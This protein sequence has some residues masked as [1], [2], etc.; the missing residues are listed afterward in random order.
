MKIEYRVGN[1][2][3]S[4]CKHILHG[5]NAQGVMG[6]G[7]AKQIR[8]KYP[9]AFADYRDAYERGEVYLGNVITSRQNDGVTIYNAISQETYGRNGVHVS[10]DALGEIFWRLNGYPELEYE[11]LA[12]PKI[13]AGL[14]GG[15][16][17][18][19]ADIIENKSKTYQPVVYEL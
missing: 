11:I 19:I 18:I 14:G 9:K 8:D 6:S 1:I 10:Y 3:N 5:C 4:P 13:G 12:M 17:N 7:I 15:D 16:W 2:L